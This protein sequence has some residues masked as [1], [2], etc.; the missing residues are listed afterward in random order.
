MTKKS[1]SL[2]WIDPEKKDESPAGEPLT[3]FEKEDGRGEFKCGNCIHMEDD[4]CNHPVMIQVSKQPR[5]KEG[6]P[7][8]GESDCCKFVR[9]PEKKE[10]TKEK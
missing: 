6:K 3:E 7:I 2:G 9:R 1:E 10:E 5:N 8:V 4:Y